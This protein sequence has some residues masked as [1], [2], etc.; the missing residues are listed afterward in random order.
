MANPS[1][2]CGKAGR[3]NGGRVYQ[4]N[5]YWF[6]F[7]EKY[8]G[9]TPLPVL[10]GWHGC[11]SYNFGDANRT[12]W[13]DETRNS[14]FEDDY[15]VVAP[16][17]ASGSENGCFGYDAD[18]TRAKAYYDELVNNYCVD[19]DRMF[20][21]GH[22]SGAHFLHQMLQDNHKA[23]WEYF[24]LRGIAPVAS[25]NVNNET[26]QV[27][28]LYIHSPSESVSPNEAVSDF[29]SGNQ[30][31]MQSTP[32]EVDACN[33]IYDGNAVNANCVSYSDC[34]TE[35][36]WC[37]HNDANYSGTFHGIPCFFKQ[38]AYDFFERL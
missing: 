10:W 27:P 32:Y 29:R 28:V 12:E 38:A 37:G 20:G 2:G 22:S 36:I 30:C 11:G 17:P 19:L 31:G 34:S 24:N 5:Q 33:S 25:G 13:Y 16:L 3:P 1:P 8:D 21:T 14:G 6:I 35:T 7:P 4:A 18:I 26:T 23:D 9:S 15:V